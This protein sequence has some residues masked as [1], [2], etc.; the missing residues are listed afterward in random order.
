M[1]VSNINGVPNQASNMQGYS[2]P[3]DLYDVTSGWF[4]SKGFSVTAAKTMAV[5]LIAS[6]IDGGGTRV[7]VLNTLKN[8]GSGSTA[9]LSQLTA[10]L[11]NSSRVPTS[12]AGY[13]TFKATNQVYGRLVI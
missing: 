4:E 10:Y 13:E 11:L 9:E 2:V 1:P 7:D 8:Y 12:Y 3:S 6:T 5:A